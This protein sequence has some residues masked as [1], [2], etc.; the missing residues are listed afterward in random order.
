MTP[1]LLIFSELFEAFGAAI[2]NAAKFGNDGST[3][4]NAAKAEGCTGT[5][6]NPTNFGEAV[7]AIDNQHSFTAA[8][9]AKAKTHL[10]VKRVL[11]SINR[12]TSVYLNSKKVQKLKEL[13]TALED[14]FICMMENWDNAMHDVEDDA[15]FDEFE[16]LAEVGI[17]A[18]EPWPHTMSG[19]GMR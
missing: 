11:D 6:L 8:M 16:E 18:E 7:A 9:A 1:T 15:V 17:S 13:R 10:C 14:H 3:D 12:H 2:F 4:G 5:E 19:W